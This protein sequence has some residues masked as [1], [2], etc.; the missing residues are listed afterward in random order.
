[1]VGE[2]SGKQKSNAGGRIGDGS[3]RSSR[4]RPA[5]EGD[6]GSTEEREKPGKRG[7]G[8]SRYSWK[9]QD[10]QNRGVASAAGGTGWLLETSAW[11][12]QGELKPEGGR[13]QRK[14]GN[15]SRAEPDSL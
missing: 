14:R 13:G 6:V 3:S 2:L 15:G 11:T 8:S 4:E 9:A 10:D 5:V 7:R 1:M 12:E